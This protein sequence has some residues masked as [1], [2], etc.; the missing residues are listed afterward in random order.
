MSQISDSTASTDGRGG[1]ERVSSRTKAFSVAFF[2]SAAVVLLCAGALFLHVRLPSWVIQA[3]QVALPLMAACAGGLSTSLIDDVRQ[4]ERRHTRL[5]VSLALLFSV[6][7]GVS[8]IVP[9]IIWPEISSVGLL[10]GAGVVS[11]IA[12]FWPSELR[13]RVG[14]SRRLRG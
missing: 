11:A 6:A 1:D 5:L 4:H 13:S 3:C 14:L 2:F 7:V 12:L 10:V 8:G 9:T